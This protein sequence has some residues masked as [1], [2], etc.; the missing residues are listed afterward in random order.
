MNHSI[1]H[2]LPA[3]RTLSL[4]TCSAALFCSAGMAQAPVLLATA[5][6]PTP[7]SSSSSS[8]PDAPD[9]IL[10]PKTGGWNAQAGVLSTEPVAGPYA[11]VIQPGQQAPKIS[12]RTEVLSG[13]RDSFTPAA[14]IGWAASEGYSYV[15]NGSPNYDQTGK[16]FAQGLGAAAAR[17]TSENIFTEAILAPILHEDPR[18]YRMG[19]GHNFV[20][21]LGYAGTRGLITRT[22]GGRQTLN[23]ANIGGNLAGSALTPVYYPPLNQSGTEVLKTFGGSVGGSALGF[24]VEEFLPDLFHHHQ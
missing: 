19:K 23:I 2:R 17:A 8:L 12:K 18:Y 10:V 13:I 6:E 16:G 14:I 5:V 1:L 22:D 4:A 15:T 20:K 11:M 7:I 21:R 3:F 24:V 9:A